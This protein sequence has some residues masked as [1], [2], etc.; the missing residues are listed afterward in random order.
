MLLINTS[1]VLAII[2]AVCSGA[3][4][5]EKR[6]QGVENSGSVLINRCIPNYRD[7]TCNRHGWHEN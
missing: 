1:I 4:A 2:V 7:P 6:Q 5:A 3:L